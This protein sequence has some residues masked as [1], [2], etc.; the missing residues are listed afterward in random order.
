MAEQRLNEPVPPPM[1]VSERA[2]KP[3]TDDDPTT[4]T[5]HATGQDQET[6]SPAKGKVQEVAGKAK[7]QVKER[8]A[9]QIDERTTQVGQQIRAQADTIDGVAEKLRSQGQ[10]GPAR[11]VEQA[12]QKV[13]DIAEYLERADGEELAQAAADV[14]RDN[15]AA[16]AAVGAAAGFA[17]GRVIKAARED[18]PSEE[19]V[20]A[21]A[22]PD[23][24]AP[25][26][27]A[28]EPPAPVAPPPVAPPP[29]D[30]PPAERPLGPGGV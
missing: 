14:A 8:A 17:A 24:L 9:T 22:E 15:P 16:A 3:P 5:E 23:A 29:A 26:P 10:D 2:V 30:L 4:A 25:E 21:A 27:L 20:P 11:V 7:E 1:Q 13:R 18:S 6:T 28:P 12:G 19:D